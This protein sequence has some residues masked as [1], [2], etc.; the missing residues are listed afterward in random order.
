MNDYDKLTILWT[1]VQVSLAV[2][3]L[4]TLFGAV[5]NA[6]APSCGSTT[7]YTDHHEAFILVWHALSAI[8][9]S[10]GGTIIMKKH[11]TPTGLGL[12]VGALLV[13][14]QWTLCAL[15][16]LGGQIHK[17][18]LM[19]ANCGKAGLSSTGDILALLVGIVLWLLYI[20]FG[21]LLVRAK[22]RLLQDSPFGSDEFPNTA[23]TSIGEHDDQLSSI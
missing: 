13:M 21:V 4:L 3:V 11:R 5:G 14:V 17:K 16:L 12:F 6:T 19:E 18:S 20:A 2:Y 15:V 7:L 1:L 10:V 22:D 9:L 23:F 8:A